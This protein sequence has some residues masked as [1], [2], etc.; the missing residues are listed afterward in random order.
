MIPKWAGEGV[1]TLELRSPVWEDQNRLE[2]WAD[3]NFMKI[4]KG[5]CKALHLIQNNPKQQ[6]RQAA[7]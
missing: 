7:N 5:K 3:R 4:N 2:K 6:V 1:N